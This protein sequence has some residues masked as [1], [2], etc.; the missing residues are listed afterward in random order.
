MSESWA[1]TCRQP[2]CLEL[3]DKA[4]VVNSIRNENQGKLVDFVCMNQTNVPILL[5]QESI[6]RHISKTFIGVLVLISTLAAGRNIL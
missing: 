4:R 5:F 2:D 3:Q 6:Y 1:K